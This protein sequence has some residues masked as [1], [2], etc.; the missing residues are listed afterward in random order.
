MTTNEDERR[1]DRFRRALRWYPAAWRSEHG[2]V[3][4]GILLDEAEERRRPGPTAGQRITLAV[5]GLG[6]R[7]R[8]GP[9]RSPAT[10]GLLAL[11]TAFF[12]FYVAVN[13]S[14]GV[15][16]PG[17]IGPFTNPS[18]LA[19]AVF[20]IALWLAV[21]GRTGAARIAALLASALELG[22]AL[23]AAAAG[24]LGPGLDTA[25][26]IAVLGL[27]AV[28]PPR[29]RRTA[30][31]AL[32]APIGLL[33]LLLGVDALGATVFTDV[34]AVRALAPLPVIAA[35]LVALALTARR[36]ARL[37]RRLLGGPTPVDG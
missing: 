2:E 23:L 5:G 13:W 17:A 33:A 15:R 1:A 10:I 6:H 22:I 37:E 18:V 26:P 34:P 4:L 19:G 35:V 8:A 9:G 14:P 32:L 16:S 28:L 11:V 24:W 29:D 21:A 36:A 31:V 7:F 20:A 25:G 12:A 30:A 3:L 27:L